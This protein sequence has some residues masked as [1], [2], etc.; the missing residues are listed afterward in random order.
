M[1]A[2]AAPQKRPKIRLEKIEKKREEKKKT[3]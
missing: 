2:K 1:L 3:K